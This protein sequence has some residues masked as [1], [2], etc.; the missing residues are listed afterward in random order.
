MKKIILS[1][2]LAVA[3]SIAV[4][5]QYNEKNLRLEA[6][7]GSATY[8]FENLQIYPIYA[9]RDFHSYHKG[10]GKFVT[11]KE[12][13]QKKKI[14]ITEHARGTVNTLFIENVSS[15]TIMILAGE[16][17]QGGKQDRMIAEDF[18]LYPKSGMK[19]ISV[20]CVEHGRWQEK[21]SGKSF[22]EYFT[23]SSNEVRKAGAVKKD[24]Q[25]VWDKVS[26]NTKK[27]N[28]GSSSGTLAALKESGSFNTALK[29]YTDHFETIFVKEA[30]VIGVVAVSGDRILGCDMFATN[31][32][33]QK[34]YVNL[35]HSYATEAI[36]SGKPVEISYE[37][38]QQYL[39]TIIGDE[40]RQERDV[41]EKGTLLKD[42]N[43]K[44]HISTF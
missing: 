43:K 5:A 44:V 40:A 35:I 1:Y 23:I 3:V 24:Q 32:L 14:V 11:L 34:H 8:R 17:V 27:N 39:H 30:N 13:I 37:K 19:D 10:V 33:F 29:K 41:K 26:D 15:D 9:N 28:A 42:G 31:G 18:L 12:G 2:Y 22:N 16:V 38:V 25:E 20:F 36:T 21:G 4:N 6:P 7:S